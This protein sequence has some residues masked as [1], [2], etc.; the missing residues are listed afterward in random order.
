MT[1]PADDADDLTP[2]QRRV[3]DTLRDYIQREGMPPSLR[4]LSTALGYSSTNAV[5]N[6]LHILLRK[7]YVRPASTRSRGW[8]P[9]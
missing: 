3:L 1:T 9:A 4:E 7:G 2:S 5:S 6:S 8:R